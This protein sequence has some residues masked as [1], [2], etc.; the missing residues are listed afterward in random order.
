MNWMGN[1]DPAV[2]GQGHVSA[3]GS[4]VA[5]FLKKR[6][7]R[8]DKSEM[9]GL[10]GGG[11][12]YSRLPVGK[13]DGQPQDGHMRPCKQ[14]RPQPGAPSGPCLAPNANRTTVKRL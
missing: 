8:Q 1:N 10:H 6:K 11:D 9:P 12:S 5:N 2:Q 14:W 7:E 13:Q 4:T 3:E